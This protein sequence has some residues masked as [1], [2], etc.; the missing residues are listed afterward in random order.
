MKVL[1]FGAFDRLHPGHESFLRQARE[2]GDHLTVALACD[3]IIEQ[4]KGRG[5]VQNFNARK[6]ALQTLAEV[7]EVVAG[8]NQLGQYSI[9]Q[10]DQYDIIALGYDQNKLK[11]DLERWFKTHDQNIA[12]KLLK[13]FKPEKYKSTI[14][15]YDR[16]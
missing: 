3:K 6:D 14:L 7:D 4:L 15:R 11:D 8:D 13:P 2:L 5:P 9:L 10:N 1:V 16:P 12:I